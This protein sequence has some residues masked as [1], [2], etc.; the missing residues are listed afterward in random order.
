MHHQPLAGRRVLVTRAEDQAVDFMRRLR[1]LGAEPILCPTIRIIAA[2]DDAPLDRALRHL[3]EVEW[4]VF[5]SVNGV[6]AV[7]ERMQVLCLP[8]MG[9]RV[10]VAAIGPATADALR[11]RGIPVTFMPSRHTAEGMIEE[12]GNVDGARMLLPLADIARPTLAHGLRAR[13]AN[14]TVVTAYRTVPVEQATFDAWLRDAPPFDVV[15]FTSSSTVHNFMALMGVERARVSLANVMVASIGP[16]TTA[17]AR[18]YGLDV[19]ITA[20]DHTAD[21]LLRA[22]VAEYAPKEML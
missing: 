6:R 9:T 19:D 13:G 12:I 8:A 3:H 16:Q 20:D 21:G 15:T 10:S 7:V 5:T 22:V 18:E 4:I 1:D 2:D 17:T 14:V 11:E